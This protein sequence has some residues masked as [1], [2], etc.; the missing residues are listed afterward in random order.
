[1]WLMLLGW[2]VTVSALSAVTY[3]VVD[4]AGEVVVRAGEDDR[5]TTAA[6][7]P[8]G[9]DPADPTG[10]GSPAPGTSPGADPTTGGSDAGTTPP[11]GGPTGGTD[12][13]PGGPDA[14]DGPTPGDDGAPGT[15]TPGPTDP[16]DP[17]ATP[18]TPGTGGPPPAQPTSPPPAP[19]PPAPT[20]DPPTPDP[21]TPTPEPSQ[22][23][24]FGTEG[25]AA[26]VSCT[27]NRITVESLTAND[28]WSF[29]TRSVGRSGV[30]MIEFTQVSDGTVV[31]VE[32]S[33]RGGR[34]VRTGGGTT[35]GRPGGRPGDA[36]TTGEMSVRTPG[37]APAPDDG[38]VRPGRR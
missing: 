26:V 1:M 31:R 34:P 14:G 20:P 2:V 3:V 37:S 12:A 19:T 10:T 29:G 27:G 13:G 6:A 4:L 21:P 8:T 11:T 33:C 7:A 23:S 5:S 17:S 24:S 28:G 35:P 32:V 15:S 36:G 30:V 9:T 16:T 25:G 38:A 18:D 22:E